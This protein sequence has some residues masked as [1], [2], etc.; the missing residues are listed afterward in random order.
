[1]LEMGGGESHLSKQRNPLLSVTQGCPM[2]LTP[3]KETE[4]GD[5]RHPQGPLPTMVFP[6]QGH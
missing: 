4:T 6:L 3:W 1:M 2:G 5:R